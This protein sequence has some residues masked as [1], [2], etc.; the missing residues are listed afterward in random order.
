[1][2]MAGGVAAGE[3]VAQGSPATGSSCSG[4]PRRVPRCNAGQTIG[5]RGVLT[6][7]SDNLMDYV[8]ATYALP[9]ASRTPQEW[10]G[11]LAG[12]HA[13]PA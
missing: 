2:I 8:L 6:P 10:A 5:H 1:M 4:L 7:R 13:V 9:R 11:H 12:V 3:V